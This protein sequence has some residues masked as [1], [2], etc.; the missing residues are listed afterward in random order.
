[1]DAVK[2]LWNKNFAILW[3]GQLISDFGNA[4]FSVALGFWV[5]NA[6]ASPGT[7]GGDVTLMGLVMACFALPEVVLGPFAG[8]LADRADRKRI[9]IAADF[10]RGLLFAATGAALISGI[11][12]F[13]M[14][15]PLAILSGACAAFFSP[16]LSSAIPDI[17]PKDSLSRANSA[18]G[19]STTLSSLLGNSLG[20]VLFA[21]AG[22]PLLILLNG[23][24]FLY[25]SVSQLFM[26]LPPVKR[27]GA[28][29]RMMRDMADGMRYAFS[30]AGLRTLLISGMLINLFAMIGVTLLTPLF[31]GTPGYGAEKYGLMMGSMM[32]GAVAG[33]AALSAVKIRADRRS[34]VFGAAIMTMVCST[35]PIGLILDVNWLYPL[36]FLAGTANAFVNVMVQTIIQSAVAARNR[37]KV[38]GI[39]ATVTGGLQ[40]LSMA[41][42]GAIAGIAGIRPAITAAFSLLV[43][44]ALP[45]LIDKNFKAFIDSDADEAPAAGGPPAGP[46]A[47]PAPPLPDE[48]E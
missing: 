1:M 23:M 33:M 28:K 19:F 43:V 37:G 15:F 41:L 9:I 29:K 27:A 26:K 47:V 44:A 11:F 45:L 36:A 24:S 8:A 13:W 40:P 22:A 35:V 39:L 48:A 5:L 6:T 17:V 3:Q 25:A 10:L 14:I 42:S 16:A 20:G 7:P 38:F 12:P 18:R 46:E 32:A 4:A 30:T 34:A 31:N 21:A 2:R